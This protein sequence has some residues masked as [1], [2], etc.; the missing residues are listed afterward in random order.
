MRGDLYWG[1]NGGSTWVWAAFPA[2]SLEAR[3][4]HACCLS[5]Q[6]GSGELEL[7]EHWTQVCK[8]LQTQAFR[9]TM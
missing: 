4:G 7:G 2:Q 1:E 5:W 8:M 3:V 6:G 9:F